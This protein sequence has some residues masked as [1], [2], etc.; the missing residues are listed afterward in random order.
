MKGFCC[1]LL[2]IIAFCQCAKSQDAEPAVES[3]E[4]QWLFELLLP[5]GGRYEFTRGMEALRPKLKEPAIWQRLSKVVRAASRHDFV[6]SLPPNV[7]TEAAIKLLGYVQND[8]AVAVIAPYLKHQFLQVR[9]HAAESLRI[10]QNPKAVPPLK[11]ALLEVESRLPPTLIANPAT[12]A[13]LETLT[14]YFRA[15]SMIRSDDALAALDASLNRLRY[16]Y[17]ASEVGG[18]LLRQLQHLREAGGIQEYRREAAVHSPVSAEQPPSP[19]ALMPSTPVST[20]PPVASPAP[21]T[22]IAQAPAVPAERRAPMWPWVVGIAAL[23]AIV[24]VALK[25]CA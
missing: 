16:R 4:A 12:E 24:A 15:L 5:Y 2:S 23:I 25:R 3:P 21:T 20:V 13:S 18:E 14:T 11:A 8:E 7:E 22:P 10:T 9:E 6:E 17:G 1:L 19:Q